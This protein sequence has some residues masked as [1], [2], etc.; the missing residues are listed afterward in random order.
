MIINPPNNTKFINLATGEK[1][2]TVSI[3]D[4]ER[5]LVTWINNY[6]L[7]VD[8]VKIFKLEQ[9]KGQMKGAFQGLEQY[10]SGHKYPTPYQFI[11]IK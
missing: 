8:N 1:I 5:Y 11:K 10:S 7:Y 3:R 4:K 6:E 9:R 2:S